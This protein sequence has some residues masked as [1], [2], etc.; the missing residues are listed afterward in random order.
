MDN[1]NNSSA[2]QHRVSPT[3]NNYPHRL[4]S[5]A[6]AGSPAPSRGQGHAFVNQSQIPTQGQSSS[7][8]HARASPGHGQAFLYQSQIPTQGHGQQPT[9]HSTAYGAPRFGA[10]HSSLQK[11]AAPQ[12]SPPV[13]FKNAAGHAGQA[14]NNQRTPVASAAGVPGRSYTVDRFSPYTRP[15][16]G[17]RLPS[18]SRPGNLQ[19]SRPEETI[20]AA[21]SA[22]QVGNIQRPPVESAT[23]AATSFD[24]R[25]RGHGQAA[26]AGQKSH[27]YLLNRSVDSGRSADRQLPPLFDDPSPRANPNT[28]WAMGPPSTTTGSVHRQMTGPMEAWE[29]GSYPTGEGSV[30]R[31]TAQP[32]NNDNPARG[33]N[34]AALFHGRSSAGPTRRSNQYPQLP[35]ILPGIGGASNPRFG[36]PVPPNP[37][38]SSIQRESAIE[39]KSYDRLEQELREVRAALLSVTTELRQQRNPGGDHDASP[40]RAPS[41]KPSNRARAP[42]PSPSPVS[43]TA[44]QPLQ[45]KKRAQ[46]WQQGPKSTEEAVP[47]DGLDLP[48]PPADHPIFGETGIMRGIRPRWTISTNRKVW[49]PVFKAVDGRAEGHNGIEVGQWWPLTLCA[50]RGKFLSFSF[51]PLS[52]SLHFHASSPV[53]LLH[54]PSSFS[55]SSSIFP[56]PTP[57]SVIFRYPPSLYLPHFFSLLPSS[58]PSHTFP[59]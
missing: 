57:S 24:N 50:Q 26:D 39:G 7:Q 30:R 4:I 33:G 20:T 59:P 54:L 27:D 21:G 56:L 43:K 22:Y 19:A 44:A 23:G 11:I 15:G 42:S 2:P 1:N 53:P 9:F 51:F 29:K 40:R 10:S 25:P 38:H 47:L 37:L 48:A 45:P 31:Q 32:T 3:N 58:S 34:P 13:G 52:L 18:L 35:P 12:A 49:K 46:G 6:V 5:R 41:P 17:I 16:H 55:S 28:K 14:T 8:A 36:A